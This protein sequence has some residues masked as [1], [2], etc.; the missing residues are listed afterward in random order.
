[1]K[2]LFRSAKFLAEDLASMILFVVILEVTHKVLLAIGVGMVVGVAQIGW[3]LVRRSPINSMQWMSVVLVLAS[4]TATFLTN[5]PRFVM[6]KPTVLDAVLGI[7]MLRRGWMNHYLPDRAQEWTADI[8][9]IFGYV[10]AG[11]MF[12]T[13][14]LNLALAMMLDPLTWG[15]VR[16]MFSIA[17]IITLFLIQFSVMRFIGYRRAAR[18]A[19]AEPA[20]A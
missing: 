18:T 16:S 17:S 14:A 12:A 13:G 6:I 4:G 11:L 3:R 20:A 2:E 10:W 8:A 1:M 9:I 19:A 7:F 15:L 5:D